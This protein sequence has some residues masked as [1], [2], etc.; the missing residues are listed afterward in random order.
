MTTRTH[1]RPVSQQRTRAT[2]R[3]AARATLH[4]QRRRQ[5]ARHERR[6]V[7]WAVAGIVALA[8]IV[9]VAVGG[10]TNPPAATGAA[11]GFTL[12]A[13]GGGEVS[14]AGFRGRSVLL[15]FN[16]GVGCDACFYQTAM[17][18]DDEAFAALGVPLVPIVM[19]TTAQVEG[20][21]GRFGIETPYLSDPSG[22]VSQS[23]DTLGTG[24]HA[25]LPGHSLILVGPEGEIRWRGDYPGMWVEP[26]TVVSTVRSYLDQPV[27][28][29][30]EE[31]R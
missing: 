1:S 20:E 11:P 6:W 29:G 22:A 13:T 25:D 3:A 10:R 28:P 31:S 8:A 19:N 7:G 9:A 5:R 27:E 2:R 18:E 15:Y 24:H 4:E 26:A 23:Y 21:L 16:E 14:L 12:P 17:L 30:S